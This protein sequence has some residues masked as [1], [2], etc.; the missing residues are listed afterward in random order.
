L[1]NKTVSGGH[2]PNATEHLRR[3]TRFGQM[4]DTLHRA[5]DVPLSNASSNTGYPEIYHSFLT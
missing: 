5:L 1:K 3:I 2:I 4:S